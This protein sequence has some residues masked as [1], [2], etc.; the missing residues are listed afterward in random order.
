PVAGCC[1]SGW[2]VG[3]PKPGSEPEPLVECVHA[4]VGSTA[5]HQ[6]VVA[7][8]R[9]G[10]FECS[11]YYGLAMTSASQ[12]GVSD[13]VLQEPVAPSTAKQIWRNDEHAGRS[14][15]IA[16]V[17]YKYMDTRV[18]QSFLPDACGAFSWLRD[19]THLRHLEQGQE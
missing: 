14:D 9:P 4:G 1:R 7:V 13:N 10:M 18:P 5:L 6:P 19:R 16:I 15:P 12:L 11:P 17:G 3:D 2:E 8:S